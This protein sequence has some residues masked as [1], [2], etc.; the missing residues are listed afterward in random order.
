MS[1]LGDA[2][3]SE[4][5]LG[6]RH[7]INHLTPNPNL[8]QHLRAISELCERLGDDILIR[9]DDG[10]ELTAGLRKLLEAKDCF[11]RQVLDDRAH[12]ER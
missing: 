3:L 11:V 7:L 8:P 9:A 4:R 1:H 2:L 6:T 12:D 5:H 10:P